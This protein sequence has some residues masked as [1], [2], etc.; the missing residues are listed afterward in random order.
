[1]HI[2]GK[3]VV[4]STNE[5]CIMNNSIVFKR[6]PEMPCCFHELSVY[7]GTDLKLEKTFLNIAYKVAILYQF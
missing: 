7:V 5:F 4:N 1:M 6:L 2:E 3:K